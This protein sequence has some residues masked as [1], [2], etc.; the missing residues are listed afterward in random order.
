MSSGLDVLGAGG[1][2]T[3]LMLAAELALCAV[4]VVIVERR[5][6][7]HVDGSRAGGLLPRSLELLDQ[8]GVVDRFLDAGSTV[9]AHGFA[10]ISMDVSDLATRHNCVLALRQ[11]EFEPMLADWV[12]RE[13][14]VPIERGTDVV[15]FVQDGSGVDTV[16][17]DGRRWRSQYLVGCD[18]GRSLVRNLAGI[19]FVG[20]DPTRSWVVAEVETAIEPAQGLRDDEAGLQGVARIG[21]VGPFRL[22]LTEPTLRSG[23]PTLDELRDALVA[24]FGSDLGLH[25]VHWMSRFTDATRQAA[26]YRDQQVLLA[27][28]AAHVDPP[29]GGQGLN[30]GVQDAV[31]L[32]WKLAQ[33]VHGVSPATLLDSY[34]AERHPVAA[35]VLHNT[36]AQVAITSGGARHRALR[37]TMTVLL[38]MD[39][40]RRY[41]A[42][43][44]T[45]LDIRY[46]LDPGGDAHPLVGW[47]MPDVDLRTDR[48]PVP[49]YAL[50]REPRP[51]LLHLAQQPRIEHQGS[52]ANVRGVVG[53]TED[54]WVLPSI[55]EVPAPAAVLIRPDGHI[56]WAG[57]PGDDD[58][59][60]AIATWC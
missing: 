12:L 46:D 2:P 32:G 19:D 38:G 16:L 45:G 58:L 33:V 23:D 37:D 17:S 27:G 3:G 60:R 18:G 30:T 34:H 22:V 57:D 4:E 29:H 31:N 21:D 35:R 50:L 53:R 41:L 9:P 40:P 5:D 8:R 7:H 49:A 24:V 51:V 1:G 20:T 6:D 15:D 56:A 54:T 48:G 39:E 11:S 52:G 26:T 10:G 59:D 44:L 42:E 47:R 55:G 36:L 14:G 43:M 28:D 25:T 13:L